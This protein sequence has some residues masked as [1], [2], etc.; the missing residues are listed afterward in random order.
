MIELK[1]EKKETVEGDG[2]EGADGKAEDGTQSIGFVCEQLC[3]RC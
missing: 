3:E 2:G 1:I